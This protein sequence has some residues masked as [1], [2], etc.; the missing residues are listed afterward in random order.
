MAV[1]NDFR[2][3]LTQGGARPSQFE[4]LL[5]FPPA[6]GVNPVASQHAKFM[7]VGASLPSSDIQS[8]EV[9]YRGRMIKVAGE[10]VFS[11]WRVTIM[12]DGNFVIREALE[13]WSN[14][15]LRHGSTAGNVTPGGVAGYATNLEVKQ[16]GRSDSYNADETTLR[17]YVFY[18]CYPI[19][20]SEIGLDFGDTNS[21]ER[22]QVE[23]SVDYWT[24]KDLTIS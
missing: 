3:H 8:I 24:T 9:P 13:T 10:R 11:N 6:A 5:T 12:N 1:I 22:F 16:L 4:V 20:I 19:S 2:A 21:I 14:S 18:N 23:F 17:H 15:I 7:C